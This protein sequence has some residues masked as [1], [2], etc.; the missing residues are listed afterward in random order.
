MIR[1]RDKSF[2]KLSFISL[3]QNLSELQSALR[4]GLRIAIGRLGVVA[5]DQDAGPRGCGSPS[6]PPA[7][8]HDARHAARDRAELSS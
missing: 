3:A 8:N 4:L 1:K 7:G 5:G 2:N 6:R